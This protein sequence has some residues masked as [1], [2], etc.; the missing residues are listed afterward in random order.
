MSLLL[1]LPIA[2]IVYAAIAGTYLLVIPL[3]VL[4]YFKARWYKTGSLERVFLCFLAFFF[5]PGLLL[6]SPFF[7]FRPQ[8]REI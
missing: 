5:F 4:F 6:L 8:M 3:I 7:N 1:S 2:P